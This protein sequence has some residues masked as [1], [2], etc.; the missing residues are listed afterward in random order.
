MEDSESSQVKE[1]MA[2]RRKGIRVHV[3]RRT[4]ILMLSLFFGYL[5]TDTQLIVEPI[6]RPE[7]ILIPSKVSES[8]KRRKAEAVQR[9][10]A[11][12]SSNHTEELRE[13]ERSDGFLC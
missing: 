13:E 4:L 10:G 1:G 9:D 2:G 6:A 7:G 8:G 3:R 12:K 5:N 11:G